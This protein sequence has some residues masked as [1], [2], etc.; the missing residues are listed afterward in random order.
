MP[1]LSKLYL[2]LFDDNFQFCLL[3]VAF[4]NKTSCMKQIAVLLMTIT[5]FISKGQSFNREDSLAID[6]AC[7]V[8]VEGLKRKSDR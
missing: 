5:P 4:K 3:T 1:A 6:K 7:K 8:Y 2:L